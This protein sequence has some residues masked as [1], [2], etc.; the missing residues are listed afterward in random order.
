M[1]NNNNNNLFTNMF[2]IESEEQP[3]PQQSPVQEPTPERQQ[4]QPTVQPQV[5]QQPVMQPQVKQQPIV[6][7]IIT[8]DS[9]K[10][11]ETPV[12][13]EPKPSL[14]TINMN[15]N[16]QPVKPSHQIDEIDDLD[17]NPSNNINYKG[18]V[19]I[20]GITLV[21]VLLAFP[22]YTGLNNYFSKNDEEVQEPQPQTQTPTQQEPTT[23][24]TPTLPPINFDMDL[25]FDKGY[26]NNPNEYHQTIAYKPEQY[27]GV[28]KCE[29]IKTLVS[30]AGKENVIIYL[31]YKD[32]M[33]KKYMLIDDLKF[34]NVNT[35]NDYIAYYQS[36]EALTSGNE[37][38]YTRILVS[39]SLYRINFTMLVDLA[40]NQAIRIP[41]EKIYYD[42]QMSYNTPIKNAMNKFLTNKSISG[43][44]YCST[45]ATNDASI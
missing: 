34:N 33:L 12:V 37:H 41:G 27:E 15:P 40:Y 6:E 45:L 26:S 38:L 4:V 44:M 17:Y 16:Y 9:N 10:P 36:L 25:S 7:E 8:L 20:L 13:E 28:I 29:N 11:I 22:I 30:S 14:E 19:I 21:V 1:E 5:I 32:L 3:P 43:N 31:Y 39:D 42:V 23:E 2:G 24:E 35:Y 18:L